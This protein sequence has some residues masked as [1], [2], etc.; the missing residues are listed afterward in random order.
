MYVSKYACRI[1]DICNDKAQYLLISL[2]HVPLMCNVT[3][4][5]LRIY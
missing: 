5:F 2:H 1:H 4:T 3:L